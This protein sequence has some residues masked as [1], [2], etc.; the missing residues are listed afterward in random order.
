[1]KGATH[2]RANAGAADETTDQKASKR[3][4]RGIAGVGG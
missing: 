3:G 1:M 2:L 4:S